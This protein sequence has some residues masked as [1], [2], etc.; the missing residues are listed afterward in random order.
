MSK[1]NITRRTAVRRLAGGMAVTGLT[2]SLEHRLTAA[3]AATGGA[4]KGRIRHS[5]CKWCYDKVP[6]ED[7]C[8]RERRW[9]SNRSSYWK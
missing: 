3:D 5:V 8:G 1:L 9:G 4:L 6:L 2:L 7:L